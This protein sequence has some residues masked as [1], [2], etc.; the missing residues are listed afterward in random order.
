[1]PFIIGTIP[2]DAETITGECN[3]SHVAYERIWIS[4]W[5]TAFI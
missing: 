1:M 4:I 3:D 5:F 2:L